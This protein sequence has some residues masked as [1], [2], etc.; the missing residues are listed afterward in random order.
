MKV[1]DIVEII[2][3]SYFEV[4]FEDDLLTQMKKVVKNLQEN[5]MIVVRIEKYII[6]LWK[7]TQNTLIMI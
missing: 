7:I 4:K 1:K 6:F 2:D 5:I 3:D